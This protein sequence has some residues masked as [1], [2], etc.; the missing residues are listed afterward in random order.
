ML[1]LTERLSIPKSQK[2]LINRK[3]QSLGIAADNFA[4]EGG[5]REKKREKVLHHCVLKR[6]DWTP[7]HRGDKGRRETERVSLSSQQE[8][9][10]Q[11]G[12]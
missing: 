2:S 1:S 9:T 3:F 10:P 8:H 6:V 11:L 7:E 12:T 4:R 5:L